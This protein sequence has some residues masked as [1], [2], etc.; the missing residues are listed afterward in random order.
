MNSHLM[1]ADVPPHRGQGVLIIV[2]NLPVPFDRRV[3]QEANALRD[4]GYLVSVICPKGKGHTSSYEELNG[5]H[6]YRHPL[7]FEA[8]GAAGYLVEYSTALFWEFILSVKVLR[9]HGFDVIHACNPPD[10]IFLIGGFY[11]FLFRKKFMF[12]QHDLNPELFEVKFGHTKGLFYK[13]LCIFEKLT[14]KCA[15]AS[16]AT[17]ETFKRI[18]IERGGMR[19]DDVAIVKSYPDL[20]RF[21]VVPADQSVRK[22][23]KH[24]V[25]YIGIMGNQDGVD[26]LVQAMA[27]LVH[28]EKRNDIGC[29]IIGSGAELEKLKKLA[30][31][32]KVTEHVTFTG[33]LSGQTLLANLCALDIGVIPDPPSA[34]NNKLSMNKVFEYMALGLPFVQFDLAQARFEA[35]DAGFV[36]ATADAKGLANAMTELLENAALQKIMSERGKEKAHHEFRWDSER[37]KLVAAYDRLF[38]KSAAS[39]KALES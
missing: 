34:C 38:Q 29:L 9:K 20:N 32:L 25:G 1:H 23:F 14:F 35:G 39:T 26:I 21:K 36:A 15:D 11:K 18:A 7:P 5:I 12:D 30:I 8:T 3:W 37:D 4:A 17:N 28:A 10:L 6:I 19:P 24:L 31:D 13:L 16:I 27:H 22:H 2:E 33:Y